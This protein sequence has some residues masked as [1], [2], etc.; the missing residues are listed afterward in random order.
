[1]TTIYYSYIESPLGQ[2]CVRGDG[3]FVT[4]LFMQRHKCRPGTEPSWRQSETPFAAVR[5]Q[6]AEY[7]AGERRQFDVPL[8]LAG[9]PFQQRSVART[10]AH[11]LR[12]D[13]HVCPTRPAHRQ[14][15]GGSA[16]WATPLAATLSRS[17]CH[18]IA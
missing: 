8:K 11:S 14:A 7:F 5:E 15:D 13:N 6:L 10:A 1:M 3:Q 17:W 18:A 4:G 16:P 2:M 12:D 9:T